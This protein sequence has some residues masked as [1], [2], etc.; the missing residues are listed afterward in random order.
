MSYTEAWANNIFIP[1]FSFRGIGLVG[2]YYYS[3][4][5]SVVNQVVNNFR[6]GVITTKDL[7][8]L[9]YHLKVALKELVSVQY[10]DEEDYDFIGD[11][12]LY[13]TD[14]EGSSEDLFQYRIWREYE[15]NDYQSGFMNYANPE[16]KTDH[17]IFY[18]I[19]DYRVKTIQR[20]TMAFVLKGKIRWVG[21]NLMSM[22]KNEEVVNFLNSE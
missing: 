3:N 4:I 16:L 7:I 8:S 1:T 5:C 13:T 11:E 18:E 21:H 15:F 6:R 17:S 19:S 9:E 12:Y 14:D 20:E 2:I 22:L 10:H